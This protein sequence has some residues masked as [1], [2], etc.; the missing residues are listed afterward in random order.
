[1]TA[2]ERDQHGL[3]FAPVQSYSG[4]KDVHP[5]IVQNTIDVPETHLWLESPLRFRAE[6]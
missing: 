2:L 1:M 6:I 5:T 3:S 4:C